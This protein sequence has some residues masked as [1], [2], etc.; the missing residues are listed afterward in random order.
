MFQL[1]QRSLGSESQKRVRTVIKSVLVFF[2]NAKCRLFFAFWNRDEMGLP[3]KRLLEDNP[4][5]ILSRRLVLFSRFFVYH[6]VFSVYITRMSD[7]NS[8][9]SESLE[10]YLNYTRLQDD[11]EKVC[12]TGGGNLR[13][14]C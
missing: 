12:K 11:V 6:K 8:V 7:T 4:P 14:E 9:S 10:P 3:V 1:C 5:P 13:V 2:L